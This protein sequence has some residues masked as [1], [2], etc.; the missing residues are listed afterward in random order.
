MSAFISVHGLAE[1]LKELHYLDRSLYTQI[2]KDIKGSADKLVADARNEFPVKP[3]IGNWH[4]TP[5]RRGASRF[6]YW[7]GSKVRSRVT[8]KV[9]GRKNRQG[10]F[11]ILRIVQRDA[12]GT[13]MDMAGTASSNIPLVKALNTAGYER[14]SRVM[15]KKI[16]EGYPDVFANINSAVNKV[17]KLVTSRLAGGAVSQRALQSERASRQSRNDRGQFGSKFNGP[18]GESG[19]E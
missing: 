9:G 1:T 5:E 13:V 18:S 17:E 14:P 8:A 10:E 4:I 3:P 15:W 6:P 11:P 19:T 2:A 7:D 12:G 16:N